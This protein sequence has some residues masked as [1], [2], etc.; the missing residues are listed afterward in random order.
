V[1]DASGWVNSLVDVLYPPRCAACDAPGSEPFCPVCREFV[2]PGGELWLGE[3][4]WAVAEF[5][6]GGAARDAIRR[7]KYDGRWELARALGG[8]MARSVAAS[9]FR[10]EVVVPVP[11][12]GERLRERGYNPARELARAWGGRTEARAV[13]RR[14]GPAQVGRTRRERMKNL[15]GAFSAD[16]A[17]VSGRRILVVDDVITTGATAVAIASEL[18]RRGARSV[19]IVACAS[20]P[21]RDASKR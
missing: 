20:A 2:D 10:F 16:P 18:R 8:A 3:L 4:D 13:R 11:T 14:R 12:T 15:L 17:R 7:M 1:I 9:P 5:E 6:Y 19:G 21:E